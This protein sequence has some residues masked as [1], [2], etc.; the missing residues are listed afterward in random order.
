MKKV[1]RITIITVI[2]TA[3]A[4]ALWRTNH[5]S[6]SERKLSVLPAKYEVE[7]GSEYSFGQ[8]DVV[9]S[10]SFG[11]ETL[12]YFYVKGDIS[13]T[14]RYKDETAWGTN[15][16]ITFIYDYYNTFKTGDKKSW[17]LVDSGWFESEIS[18][19]GEEI[20][21]Q[22]NIDNGAVVVQ[23][24]SDK[25]N[26]E[27]VASISDAFASNREGLEA[28]YTTTDDELKQGTFYR[29]IVVYT[30]E[31]QTKA[32]GF[33]KS[34]EYDKGTFA[35]VYEFFICSDKVYLSVYDLTSRKEVGLPTT[36]REG[37]Y[38]KKNGSSAEI[39]VQ[40]D[41]GAIT[42]PIDNTTYTDQGEYT[43]TVTTKLNKSYTYQ[44]KVITGVKF[45]EATPVTYDCE[46]DNGYMTDNKISGTAECCI[47]SHS[48]L[49]IGHSSQE[50]VV[51]SKH[52]EKEAYGV[53]GESV[54]FYISLRALEKDWVLSADT[55]GEK[56]SE[57]VAGVAT[58]KVGKGALII[59]K[60]KYGYNY[61]NVDFGR[62][63]NGLYTTDFETHYGENGKVLIYTPSGE[64]IINGM[65]YRVLY[66]Y[67]VKNG[68]T[69]K[70]YV[71]EYVFY[72]CSA[73]TEAVVFHNKT[74]RDTL[75]ASLSDVD[76][77]TADIYRSSETLTSGSMTTTG[78]TVD[79]SKNPIASVTIKK[80]GQLLKGEIKEITETGKYDIT[81]T[82]AVG[83]SENVTIYVDKASEKELY[84]RYFEDGFIDGVRVLYNGNYPFYEGG[85]R[86]KY[87]ISRVSDCYLPLYGVITNDDTGKIITIDRTYS[88]KRGTII[89][90]G[91][92]TAVFSTNPTFATG[93]KSGD[94][95]VFT[96]RFTI[97][98]EGT[99]PGP[100]VNKQR[101]Y[102]YAKST[103]ADAYPVFYGLTYQSAARGTI[104]LAFATEKA[105]VDFAYKYETGDAE[106]VGDGTFN[107]KGTSSIK[108]GMIEY[109]GSFVKQKENY[110]DGWTLA[111]AIYNY[112]KQ[113]VQ[114]SFFNYGAQY[115]IR[116]EIIK[117]TENLRQ[118]E[119]DR[120]V[121]VFA[122]DTEKQLLTKLDATIPFIS[123]KL[124]LY[125]GKTGSESGYSDFEFTRDMYGADSYEVMITDAL[126]N[127]YKI[128]YNKSVG[129]Q[130]EKASCPSGI[131]TIVEKT[132]WGQAC[133][134]YQAI[135]VAKNDNNGRITVNLSINGESWEKEYSQNDCS[136]VI[137]CDGFFIS[138]IVDDLDPY[139]LITITDDKGNV[140]F[141]AADETISDKWVIAGTYTIA[142]K[143][144]L[145]YGFSFKIRVNENSNA[146]IAFEGASSE[147][148]SAIA[149][150]YGDKNVKLPEVA[151]YGYDF[152]GYVDKD[153]NIY[154]SEIACILF[155]GQMVLITTW[156]PKTFVLTTVVNNSEQYYD[157]VY[158]QKVEI[159]E[160]QIPDG[161]E[162]VCWTFEGKDYN[163][164]TYKLTTENDVIFVAKLKKVVS[165]PTPAN[166]EP[167]KDNEDAEPS[168]DS[169]K[170]TEEWDDVSESMTNIVV[171][172]VIVIVAL[173]SLGCGGVIWYLKRRKKD[174]MNGSEVK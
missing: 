110:S 115:T 68:K 96:F 9:S 56:A 89:E 65:Y 131:V 54:G 73:S 57:T 82:T 157:I 120:S 85:T 22:K 36:V 172:V 45:A 125:A 24:S 173:G 14:S 107:Y 59:Q 134:P 113:S 15:G 156:K 143:N 109:N 128:E 162:F 40:K 133:E 23:R 150:A 47:A 48:R 29:I 121:V 141:Y 38:I 72:L 151:R 3:I 66:A 10:F 112:A 13:N 34:A 165:T 41:K 97:I 7:K 137:A 51:N 130:L 8:D 5:I 102:E 60:S 69:T 129:D 81:I 42:Y 55:W 171:T 35:E 43:I 169:V 27:N 118:L 19:N 58:G 127:E 31:K 122:N 101:L 103:I 119:L 80:D 166:T 140:D 135:Y 88:E 105:A 116:E 100:V 144:R 145:G 153:G 124:Y 146:V 71:E 114:K 111:D 17:N 52:S 83:N 98:E 70:N 6:A 161:F 139:G 158:G 63:A 39:K 117:N 95:R 37:F 147:G 26:W 142:Y 132:K 78:F 149:V 12:G 106:E 16:N 33:L 11:Q 152:G 93:N 123:D 86:T 174:I 92:Y 44:V 138:D 53:K 18:I 25:K 61:E 75:E 74:V 168:D 154:E 163:E 170:S 148:L 2:A 67:E 77:S 91:S 108:D 136:E 21:T 164:N 79:K 28:L 167:V 30:M 155:K 126:G 32:G 50:N 87:H 159:P 94:N 62:Y 64:D 49:F 76:N 160:P 1:F 20:K 46:V 84:D 99:A 104:T 4:V 90:A